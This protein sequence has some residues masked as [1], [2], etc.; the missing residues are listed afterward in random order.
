MSVT[1]SISRTLD[2]N[3]T[4]RR[5]LPSLFGCLC[6]CL[7]TCVCQSM[8]PLHQSSQ[9]ESPR[10]V[11]TVPSLV[12]SKHERARVRE[13][14]VWL[15]V[16]GKAEG[17]SRASLGP[18]SGGKTV[19]DKRLVMLRLLYRQSK[20]KTTARTTQELNTGHR[21]LFTTVCVLK[22]HHGHRYPRSLELRA[23]CLEWFGL[24]RCDLGWTVTYSGTQ[25]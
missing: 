11:S 16:S 21:S 12:W 9:L 14:L 8:M 6:E 23:A 17:P 18:K 25:V 1:M 13:K 19:Q 5:T 4:V 2:A 7:N 10:L 3:E 15:H 24:K 20:T 22:R